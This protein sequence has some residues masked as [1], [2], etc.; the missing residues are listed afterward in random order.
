MDFLILFQ[1]HWGWLTNSILLWQEYLWQLGDWLDSRRY[2]FVCLTLA[3][4][5]IVPVHVVNRHNAMLLVEDSSSPSPRI[6][7]LLTL[8]SNSG[9][10]TVKTD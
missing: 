6:C 8:T 1:P 7:T 2:E 4:L 5:D 3:G 9:A 10:R